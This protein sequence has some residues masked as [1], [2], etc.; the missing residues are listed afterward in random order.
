MQPLS[1]E[2]FVVAAAVSVS[3]WALA[4]EQI[5][6]EIRDVCDRSSKDQQC[7]W[8]IRKIA[9]MPTCEYCNSFWIALVA[10]LFLQYQVLWDDWRGYVLAQ[11]FTWSLAVAY[12]SIYQLLRVDIRHGQEKVETEKKAQVALSDGKGA[13]VAFPR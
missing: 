7:S 1:V 8:L 10:L 4:K 11:F 2:P 9:Y 5:F 6:R 3:A 12:M 13:E